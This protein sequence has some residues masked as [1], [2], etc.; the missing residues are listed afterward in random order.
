[1]ENH[2]YNY[3]KNYFKMA[4][5]IHFDNYFPKIY[6]FK[7]SNQSYHF[8]INYFN[9]NFIMRNYLNFHF[10]RINSFNILNIVHRIYHYKVFNLDNVNRGGCNFF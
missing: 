8:S 3:H 5:I 7:H 9:F 2:N 1:M 10:N 4:I 6:Y